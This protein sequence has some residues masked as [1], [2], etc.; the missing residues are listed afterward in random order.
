MLEIPEE[1]EDAVNSRCML[2]PLLSTAVLALGRTCGTSSSA[3][4]CY[5][6]HDAHREEGGCL[7]FVS[8]DQKPWLAPARWCRQIC[9]NASSSTKPFW[10]IICMETELE[11]TL[12]IHLQKIYNKIPGTSS[13]GLEEEFKKLTSIKIQNDKM[14]TGN[15]PANMKKNRVLQI[16]PYEFNR[17]I[18]PVKRGEENTDYV[19]ASFIDGYRQK[20]SYITAKAPPAHLLQTSP[21]D[22]L[23]E[24]SP[25]PSSYVDRA[26]RS[27]VRRNVPSTGLHLLRLTGISPKQKLYRSHTV[28]FPRLAGGR[29]PLLE[30]KGMINI[31]A[32]VQKQQQQSETIPSP[33][34]AALEQDEQGPSVHWA[35]FGKSQS[36]RDSGCLSDGEELEVTEALHGP[37]HWN[38]T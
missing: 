15:L 19:N 36:R 21:M 31:I 30:W 28:P 27:G 10:S 4:A 26:G 32:A 13:N 23:G 34:T 11:V 17:V 18:I 37:K 25:A 8:R 7:R 24:G 9:S 38:S 3:M 29:H 1:G 22:D 5:A 12:E 14:R 20:D 6:G 35:Q 33:P 16:I 2:G